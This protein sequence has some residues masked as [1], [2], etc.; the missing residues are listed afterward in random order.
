MVVQSVALDSEFFHHLPAVNSL[1]VIEAMQ[2]LFLNFKVLVCQLH[3]LFNF[4]IIRNCV[5]ADVVFKVSLVL[6][7]LHCKRLKLLLPTRIL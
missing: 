6:F 1:V 2:S 3:I 7:N 4:F 5:R